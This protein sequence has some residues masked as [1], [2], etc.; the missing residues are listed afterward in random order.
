MIS[1]HRKKQRAL[2]IPPDVIVRM[3]GQLSRQRQLTL[4][5][6]CHL[7]GFGPAALLLS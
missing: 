6:S 2:Q 7:L 3:R 4:R 1:S 5:L